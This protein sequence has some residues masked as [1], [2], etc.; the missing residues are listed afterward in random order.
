MSI[1]G[2]KKKKM[3]L[4][5]NKA[6]VHLKDTNSSDLWHKFVIIIIIMIIIKYA[7]IINNISIFNLF[8]KI[9]S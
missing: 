2:T 6:I 7:I 9:Q 1:W 8:S 3:S 4:S 5:H